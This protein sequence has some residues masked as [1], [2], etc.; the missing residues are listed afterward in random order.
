MYILGLFHSKHGDT[1]T[2]AMFSM[3]AHVLDVDTI[4]A[5]TV[6]NIDPA[7]SAV[8]IFWNEVLVLCI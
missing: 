1:L 8:L 7:Y 6:L 3:L 4:C 2:L 5:C